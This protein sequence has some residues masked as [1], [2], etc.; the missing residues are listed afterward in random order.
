MSDAQVADLVRSDRIDVLVDLM[1]HAG[2]NRLMVFARKP[3]PVQVT[4]LAYPGTTGLGE[5]DYRLTDGYLDGPGVDESLYS[6]RSVRLPHCFWCYPEP[7]EAPQVV[8]PPVVESGYVTF[9][10]LNSFGKVNAEMMAEWAEV[11]SKVKDSRLI[12][13]A[14]EG[15]H[16][17]RARA[18]FAGH[19]IDPARVQ[20]LGFAPMAEYF[21]SYGR[22]DVALD[23]HPWAGGTT[24]CDA[25]WMGA[26][27]VTLAG[28]TPLSRGGASILSNAGLEGWVAK[29]REEYVRIAT[30]L[31]E[32]RAGLQSVRASLRDRMRRSPLMDA[33]GFTRDV[34]SSFRG[35][36]RAWCGGRVGKSRGGGGKE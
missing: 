33:A 15:G 7:A 12:L 27:V 22:I 26:P 28:K 32:D 8:P 11:L 21:G 6:E 5:M 18:L 9:G 36:W 29:S 19:G 34:E 4:Y 10:C 16:R 3:A 31:A 25:L 30:G 17:E 24:T 1:M 20:F 2:T 13:H 23:T 14:Q 35:M